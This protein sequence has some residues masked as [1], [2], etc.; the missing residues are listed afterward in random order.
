[1]NKKSLLPKNRHF[2]QRYGL[3]PQ[4]IG[5]HFSEAA[6]RY[7]HFSDLQQTVGLELLKMMEEEMSQRGIGNPHI[8]DVGMG[9]GWLT[10]KIKESFSHSRVVGVDIAEDMV[11]FSVKNKNGH[12]AICADAHHLPFKPAVFDVVFSNS[13]YQWVLDLEGAFSEVFDVLREGGFFY[14]SCFAK[15]SLKEVATTFKRFFPAVGED[16]L[17][18]LVGQED[19]KTCLERCGFQEITLESKEYRKI[20]HNLKDILWWLKAVGANSVRHNLQWTPR[21]FAAAQQFYKEHFSEN[22]NVFTTF[23][24][25]VVKAK[26]GQYKNDNRV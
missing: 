15:N 19:L 9:T 14:L 6:G 4:K 22:R 11:R 17:F 1:M 20:F 23:E 2:L 25:L 8:L 3:H 10:K 24:I 26:K 16:S 5:M 18:L 21:K 7:D 13:V 12:Y